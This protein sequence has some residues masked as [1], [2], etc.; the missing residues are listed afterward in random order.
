MAALDALRHAEA[1]C[2]RCEL[3]RY[4]TQVVPGEGPC[5]T[6]FMPIGKP[7]RTGVHRRRNN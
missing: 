5:P 7:R 6:G 1:E 3:Y 2:W 4:A